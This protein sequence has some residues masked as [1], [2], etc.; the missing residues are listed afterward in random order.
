MQVES[1]LANVFENYKSLDEHPATDFSDSLILVPQTAPLALAPAVQIYTLLHDILS[2]G[3][4]SILQKY[5]Q[6]IV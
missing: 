2:E 3:A 5:L 1:L 4:Q 6:V